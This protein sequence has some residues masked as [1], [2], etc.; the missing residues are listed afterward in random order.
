MTCWSIIEE[1]VL[2]SFRTP[3]FFPVAD[4]SE[5]VRKFRTILGLKPHWVFSFCPSASSI[6]IP[7][8]I[9]QL[10]LEGYKMLLNLYFPQIENYFV[11]TMHASN[12]VG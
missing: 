4:N 5:N 7:R 3:V 11:D 2:T 12:N 8:V 10:H 9:L 1:R 6:E